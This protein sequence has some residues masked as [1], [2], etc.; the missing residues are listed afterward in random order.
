MAL[1]DTRLKFTGVLFSTCGRLSKFC[2]LSGFALY[3]S[4]DQKVEHHSYD[5]VDLVRSELGT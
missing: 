2:S 3:Y 5:P 4:P 1:Q